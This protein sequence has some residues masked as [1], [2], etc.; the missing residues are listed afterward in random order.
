MEEWGNL[1]SGG[2]LKIQTKE[3]RY[4]SKREEP[5]SFK[6]RSR[7]DKSRPLGSR[8]WKASTG[9]IP[10]ALLLRLG[11]SGDLLLEFNKCQLFCKACPGTLSRLS[12]P[13]TCAA[14]DV[15]SSLEVITL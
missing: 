1:W 6:I 14:C 10:N 12:N 5:L 2:D 9:R 7:H 13:L 15:F 8:H 3:F 11:R 4:D